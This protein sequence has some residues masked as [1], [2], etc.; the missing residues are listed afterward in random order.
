MNEMYIYEES[1]VF[2][3]HGAV[4]VTR[5]LT[6]AEIEAKRRQGKKRTLFV[7]PYTSAS[8]SKNGVAALLQKYDAFRDACIQLYSG[9]RVTMGSD[10]VLLD[11]V[12][13]TCVTIDSAFDMVHIR[14][15]YLPAGCHD[16][17]TQLKPSKKGVNVSA[18]EMLNALDV[19]KELYCMME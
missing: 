9:L 2:T 7:P 16:V 15:Y 12:E 14:K 11:P 17:Y 18:V 5:F 8:I 19:I 10:Y 3:D 1:R 6:E 13:Y 4:T